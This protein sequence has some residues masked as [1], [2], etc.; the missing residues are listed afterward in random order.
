MSP[1]YRVFAN[2]LSVSIPRTIHEALNHAKWKV[3]VMEEMRALDNN[4]SWDIVDLPT[5][6]KTVNRKW[7]FTVKYMAD[8]DT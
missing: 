7:V 5:E 3:A 6:E 4:K 8:G 2:F 1:T